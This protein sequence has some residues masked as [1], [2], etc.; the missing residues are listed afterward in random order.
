MRL[1]TDN[2]WLERQQRASDA[3][4]QRRH[5]GH[6]P[7]DLNPTRL[8]DTPRTPGAGA[9]PGGGPG[10][11]PN[12]PAQPAEDHIPRFRTP[13]GHFSNPVDI[14][15]AATRHLESLLI[16][17]N[18]PAKIEA[19]NTIEMLKM[20]VVQN[21]QF[22]HSLER[23]DKKVSHRAYSVSEPALPRYLHWSE[24]T[25]TWSREDH[26]PRV[27]NPGDLALVVAPQ[28]GGYTLSK[29]LMDGGSS[30]N[31]LYFDTFQR[32]NLLE[33]DLMPSTTVF[34]G[35]VPGKSAYP[36]GRVRLT[37]AFGTAQNYRS[38]SLI[39]EVVK[40]KSP[41][42]ALF[43]RPAY[44]RFM[45]R[46]CYVY[47]KLKMPGPKGPITVDGDRRIAKECEEGDAAYAE[48]ACAAEELK[49]HRANVDPADMSPLKKPTTDSESPLKFKP[50]D[51]TKAIDFVPGD[52]SKQFTIGTGLDPK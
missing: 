19:R 7:H 52:S 22:S 25:I 4:H 30:I 11:P 28:V 20:A 2:W 44:A 47:L 42:H 48:V 10:R 14:V 23:R 3:V 37:V 51:D 15:L 29:V 8:F 33:K 26:P 27:D 31:I 34:H 16:H 24:Q 50:T 18:T 41:Y 35:I 1:S 39:F 6:L 9:T 38:E 40:L 46:P 12:P 43:G 17:G 32:M 49:H 36:I 5:Q 13:Q 45:A 21:A